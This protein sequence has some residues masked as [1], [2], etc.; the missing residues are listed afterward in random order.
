MRT[1]FAANAAR[2]TEVFSCLWVD[3]IAGVTM[4]PRALLRAACSGIGVDL[5]AD[6]SRIPQPVTR[7]TDARWASRPLRRML[8][9]LE[10]MFPRGMG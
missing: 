9:G 8:A 10:R 5:M 3:T 1:D 7:A 2:G 4:P 6:R